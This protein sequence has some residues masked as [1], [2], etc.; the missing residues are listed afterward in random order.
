[1]DG[2]HLKFSPFHGENRGS[3]PLGRASDFNGLAQIIEF[4]VSF[5]SRSGFL[6]Y[7]II[8]TNPFMVLG[9]LRESLRS[10]RSNYL[11]WPTSCG[12]GILQPKNAPPAPSCEIW[13]TLTPEIDF[14]DCVVLSNGG[15]H[16]DL[17]R[18]F[19]EQ[20]PTM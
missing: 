14:R 4:S 13:A 12:F 3:I 7:S 10:R 1:M 18:T 11:R 5:V 2:S 16:G 6:Y 17:Y 8:Q 9:I 20:I 19:S 15:H